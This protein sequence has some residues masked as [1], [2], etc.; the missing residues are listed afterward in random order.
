MD[1]MLMLCLLISLPVLVST[2]LTHLICRSSLRRGRGVHWYFSLI[3]AALAGG[4]IC[5]LIWLGFVFQHGELPGEFSAWPVLLEWLPVL[6]LPPTLVVTWLYRR[7][8]RKEQ[9]QP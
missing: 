9:K 6:V 1:F 3:G 2:Y 4:F 5:L 8:S 7:K